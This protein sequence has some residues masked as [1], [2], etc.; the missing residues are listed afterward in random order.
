MAWALAQN[1]VIFTHD[2]DFGTALALTNAGG[3]SV[4]QV[5][6]QHVLPARED[7][8][9]LGRL[10]IDERDVL[11]LGVVGHDA[12]ERDLVGAVGQQHMGPK[13]LQNLVGQVEKRSRFSHVGRTLPLSVLYC[14]A[15]RVVSGQLNCLGSPGINR[16][17]L[18]KRQEAGES[19]A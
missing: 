2:L 18:K 17:F 14:L 11:R 19:S 5:R 6:G 4:L 10:G 9:A 1:R 8:Q 15:Q 12:V 3:P 16:R 7:G 13:P